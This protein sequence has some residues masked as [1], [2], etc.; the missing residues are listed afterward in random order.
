MIALN[1][2]GITFLDKEVIRHCL[3]NKIHIEKKCFVIMEGNEANKYDADF[4][5]NVKVEDTN[6]RIGWIPR[7]HTVMKYMNQAY[8]N[9]DNEAY[10]RQS[11][12]FRLLEILR[13]NIYTDLTTNNITPIGEINNMLFIEDGKFYNEG[14]KERKLA[15]ISCQFKYPNP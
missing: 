11:E 6:Y 2:A 3:L 8:K 14:T 4:S 12:R 7:T 9:K 13:G 15:S 5:V 10:A 1:L